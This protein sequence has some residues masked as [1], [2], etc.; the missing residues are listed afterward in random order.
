[1][2]IPP[3]QKGIEEVGFHGFNDFRHFALG[4]LGEVTYQHEAIR[5]P[6]YDLYPV[7]AIGT[8]GVN[9]LTGFVIRL[10]QHFTDG[11]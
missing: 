4:A 3:A 1:L 6:V 7:D 8:A 10:T 5:P 9:S 2:Y 11:F